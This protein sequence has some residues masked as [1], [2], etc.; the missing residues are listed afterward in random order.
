[1]GHDMK[2]RSGS[3][4][5]ETSETRI[6]VT[7]ALDGQDKSEIDT[8]LP[9]F[10]HM[11]NSLARHGNFDLRIKAAGDL[12]VDAHHTIEDLG[13]AMGKALRDALRDK[14]ALA[15]F[16]SA[17]VPMD[18]A[19]ARV[20]VDVSGRPHLSYRAEIDDSL[21]GGINVRLFREFFQGLVNKSGLTVHIDLL[22]GDEV[23]HSLEAIFKAFSR[24]L[25]EATRVVSGQDAVLSTKGSLD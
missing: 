9:F 10:D 21:A 17:I 3:V 7:W 8:G 15:R 2:I 14:R 11:L 24:A 25:D 18:E 20:V 22:A 16:G 12:E 19:L 1:M 6:T 4:T 5:R 13:L 23:H